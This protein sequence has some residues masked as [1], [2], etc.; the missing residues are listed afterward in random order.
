MLSQ[1]FLEAG[2]D[3]TIS[4]GGILDAI[5]GNIRIGHVTCFFAVMY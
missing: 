1:I 2:K 4:V 5:K 3:P